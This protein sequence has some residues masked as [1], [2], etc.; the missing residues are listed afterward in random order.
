M[1]FNLAYKNIKKSIKDYSIYFFTLVVAVCIFY[2]FNSLDAQKSILILNSSKA[3]IVEVLI[4]LLGYVSVFISIILGFLIIYS[5]NFLIKRRKKEFGLYLTLG[6]S[7]TKVS[8]V[9][10]LETLLVGLISLGVGLVLGIFLSQLLSIFT[11]KL[12]EVNM[13]TFKFV[14]SSNA[15]I[16]TLIYFGIIFILVMIFNVISINK[17][18]LINLLNAKKKNENV[19]FHNKFTIVISFI[20]AGCLLGYA[21]HLLFKGAMF[22]F[23]NEVITMLICGAIGT[24]FLF[25]SISGVFLKLA[26]L[27]KKFYYKGL[28]MFTLKQISSKANTTVMSTTI[29]CLML[30]LT[31]GILSGS[32]SLMS[33]LNGDISNSNKID[34]TFVKGDNSY[35]VQENGT[36]E[37]I[38][39]DHNLEEITK[40]SFFKDYV[41]EYTLYNIYDEESVSMNSMI[42]KATLNAIKK[43]YGTEANFDGPLDIIKES[44]YNKLMDMFNLPKNKITL[45]ENEYLLTVDIEKA[46]EFYKKNYESGHKITVNKTELIPTTKQIVSVGFVNA[47]SASNFGTIIVPDYVLENLIPRQ[48]NLLINYVDTNKDIETFEKEFLDK[49]SYYGTLSTTSKIDIIDNSVSLKAIIT[50]VGLYVGIIF[51]ISSATILAIKELSESSDNKER[52]LVLKQIGAEDK[53]INKALFIQIAVAFGLPLII[54]IFHAFFGLRELNGMIELLGHMDLSKSIALTS[55]FIIIVYGGYFVATYITSKSIIKE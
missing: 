36:Y 16:K 27:N 45:K 12:F 13:S 30:L 55:L 22:S 31:I 20:L 21:Y 3:K 26:E 52:F 49:C 2:T 32:I 4:E 39:D 17:N 40:A 23:N 6:M 37:K 1:S 38:K 15:L 28:N 25:F 5:N 46:E 9:L 53:M 19:K 33:V 18:K 41:K 43:E 29:I 54:A 14:F 50:F 35:R 24:Y 47:S 51:A 42:D 7:K 10:V 48:N 44:D 8:S 34:L 11:A